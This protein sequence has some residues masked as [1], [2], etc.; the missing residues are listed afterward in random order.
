[1]MS[2]LRSAWF[3]ILRITYSSWYFIRWVHE[4]GPIK[5]II[6]INISR[7]QTSFTHG[8][9]LFGWGFCGRMDNPWLEKLRNY[10]KRPGSC[11]CRRNMFN[12]DSWMYFSAVQGALFNATPSFWEDG[13]ILC[14]DS[15]W[16][17]ASSIDTP[18]GRWVRRRPTVRSKSAICTLLRGFIG[19]GSLLALNLAGEKSSHFLDN[20]LIHPPFLDDF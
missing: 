11:V 17:C 2:L 9:Y 18:K 6:P 5:N 16:V 15:L 19:F 10:G 8:G 13:D 20:I 7:T 4:M 12:K 1:M 14:L 3:L